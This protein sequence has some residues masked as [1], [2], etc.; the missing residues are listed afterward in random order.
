MQA[1]PPTHTHESIGLLWIGDGNEAAAHF[2]RRAPHVRVMPGE[3]AGMV[4]A[5]QS[6]TADLLVLDSTQPGIDVS[7]VLGHL[8]A[9]QLDTPVL[10]LAPPGGEDLAIQAGRFAV[11]D[12]VVKTAD[13]L[14]QLLPAIGQLRAR[15]DLVALFRTN[16][17]SQDRLRT[18]LE[19][20]PAVTSVIT[21]DGIITAM[22]QAGLTLL[23]AAR[24]QVVGRPFVSLL[25]DDARHDANAFISRVCRGEA[26]DFD[27]VVLRQGEHPI[28]VRTRAV[29]FRTGETIVAL[30]TVQE[31]VA[32]RPETNPELEAL[33]AA[34]LGDALSEIEALRGQ[35]D[36]WVT[37]R[38]A[39]ESRAREA[40]AHADAVMQQAQA[41]AATLARERAEW[42]LERQ[43]HAQRQRQAEQTAADLAQ[44]TAAL[45]HVHEELAQA[46]A[47][48]E[49][50]RYA[51]EGFE[52][53]RADFVPLRTELDNLRAERGQWLSE[54]AAW[55]AEREQWRA[56]RQ[57]FDAREAI[58]R[59]RADAALAQ[60]EADRAAL[61]R[62]LETVQAQLFD[63]TNAL[64]HERSAWAQ[65]RDNTAWQHQQALD[66]TR[67]A[68]EQERQTVEAQR[69]DAQ[70]ALDAERHR[71]AGLLAELQEARRLSDDLSAMQR[72]FEADHSAML[73]LRDDLLRFM[74]DADSQC[75]SI[76]EQHD[77]RLAPNAVH[78]PSRF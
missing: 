34:A 20:Q 49:S 14:L 26:A 39:Y 63:A 78:N 68:L 64:M 10:L 9:A 21:P 69:W 42:A 56:E 60:S 52:T 6:G 46:Q 54:Q 38:D 25:P 19:F 73:K 71:S 29:P 16:R 44:A 58:D 53:L 5:L 57:Q 4:N 1:Q 55:T 62:T 66:A 30:A 74:A 7:A 36:L 40:A 37:Q 15:H 22:N 72:A 32:A 31:R 51:Q 23:G 28:A 17:Q 8:Q 3:A 45:Q 18:I 33:S 2:A 24:D 35:R 27:H 48:L 70:S 76:L 77:A 43:Q 13:Y 61:T 47:T 59:Q 50:L 75:R 11:C 65:E 67:S 12:C 41:D